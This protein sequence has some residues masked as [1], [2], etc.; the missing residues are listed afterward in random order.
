[1]ES[2]FR[3]KLEIREANQSDERYTDCRD[4]PRLELRDWP[5]RK[6]TFD[7]I[8]ITNYV[9][10]NLA[11]EYCW[12]TYAPYSPMKDTKNRPAQAYRVKDLIYRLLN[13]KRIV[14]GAVI[15]WGGGG[16][17]T[18]N[19]DFDDLFHAFHRIGALQ[20]L[21]TN[22]VRVPRGL[23]DIEVDEDRLR[24]L[25]SLDAGT[26][27][28]Y[29]KIK[30]RDRFETV[31]RNLRAYRDLGAR[32]VLKY[33]VVSGNA[34]ESEARQFVDIAEEIGVATIITDV[35]YNA[36]VPTPEVLATLRTIKTLA[37]ERR[38][39]CRFDAVGSNSV[40]KGLRDE[41]NAPIPR[42]VP[43]GSAPPFGR[44]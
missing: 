16:E 11:C 14:H 38:I 7:W 6:E 12:L 41:L 5:R 10:C 26:A 35:D 20:W 3:K 13:E 42:A 29:R 15:D 4:C 33:I 30:K 44:S 1:L 27:D 25:C 37:N 18:L 32:V 24:I 43:P 21:H 28:T 8:G 40:A 22:A 31:V 36:P 17:P 34:V 23:D 2:I 39:A 19:P 9:Y